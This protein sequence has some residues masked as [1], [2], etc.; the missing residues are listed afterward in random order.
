MW[1]SKHKIP[2]C[3]HNRQTTWVEVLPPPGIECRAQL[4]WGYRLGELAFEEG[5]D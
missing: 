5:A 3:D 4:D 1:L 2:L